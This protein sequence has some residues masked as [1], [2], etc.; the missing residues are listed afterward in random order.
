MTRKAISVLIVGLS[1][2]GSLF[3]QDQT[4][5]ITGR[6]LDA[7][8]LQPIASANVIIEGLPFG[9]V[10][11]SAGAFVINQVP[12]GTHQVTARVIGYAPVTQEVTVTGGETATVD[13][14]L[15]IQALVMED[16][17]ATG[18]G[19]QERLAIT[20]SVATIDAT[21]ADVGVI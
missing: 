14:S 21:E 16:I 15:Q 7:S 6:V 12:A 18:Y 17:V 20:G 5:S 3:A 13:F 4:G 2:A 11:G 10:S 1:W 9:A 8:N 19:T